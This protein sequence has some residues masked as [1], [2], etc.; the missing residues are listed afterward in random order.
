MVAGIVMVYM[1]ASGM[2]LG[3]CIIL[4]LV[5]TAVIGFA[6]ERIAYK[7]LRSAPRMSIMISAIGVSYLIQ[8]CALYFTGGLAKVYPQ[9]PWLSDTVQIFGAAT[10]RVTLITP[11]L[12]LVLVAFTPA[13][14]F[15]IDSHRSP[16]VPKTT[17]IAPNPMDCGMVNQPE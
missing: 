11:L 8:N 15:S 3:I 2:P 12:T 5:I 4:D 9:L 13:W 16:K 1:A 6:I 17:A 10:K 7:P 14:R